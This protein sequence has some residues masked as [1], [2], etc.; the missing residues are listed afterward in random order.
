MSLA[1]SLKTAQP[2]KTSRPC[3]VS[4]LLKDLSAK[5]RAALEAALAIAKGEPGRLSSQQLSDI[6]KAEGHSVS[7]KV[8]EIH[9]KGA[10]ACDSRG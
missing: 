2:Y 3:G 4:R 10:C 5:D 9:R 7:M 6:L 1:D 8:L